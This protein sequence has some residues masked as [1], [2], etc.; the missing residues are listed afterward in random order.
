MMALSKPIYTEYKKVAA[1]RC[2]STVV[3]PLGTKGLLLYL[4]LYIILN[5]SKERQS[6][7]HL[8]ILCPHYPL[9]GDVGEEVRI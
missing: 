3:K 2:E 6:Y 8:S 1:G 9:L 4:H 7:M 5:W